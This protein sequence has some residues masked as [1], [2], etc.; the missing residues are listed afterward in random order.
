MRISTSQTTAPTLSNVAVHLALTIIFLAI[1]S[2]VAAA[3][4]FIGSNVGGGG[5]GIAVADI[6]GDGKLDIIEANTG[7]TV[8]LGN[9]DGTFQAPRQFTA[10]PSASSIVVADINGDGKLDV[11]VSDGST[12]SIYILLGNGDGTFQAARQFVTGEGVNPIS[13]VA[14]DFN[15]D[16]KLDVAVGDQGCPSGCSSYTIT[17]MLG[18][19]DGTLQAPQHVTVPGLPFGL[20]VADLNKDGKQ[21]LAVT[22]GAGLVVILL[23]NGDGTFQPPLTNT[24]TSGATGPGNVAVADF[25]RDGIPD[26]AVATG[27]GQAV[28]I[29]LGHGDGTFASPKNYFDSLSDVPNFVAVGD[30]NG[31][32]YADIAIAET[33]WCPSTG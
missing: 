26:L 28:A 13:I 23:G 17:V 5:N 1:T 10:G 31:D 3:V 24:L 8:L 19:G 18:N 25:N 15:G 11:A 2:R 22:A 33:G 12:Y 29:L 30:F 6:N 9:A 4:S 21:D 16:G 7:V 27:E 20:A 32:G 14:A